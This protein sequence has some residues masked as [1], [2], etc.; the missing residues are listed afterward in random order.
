MRKLSTLALLAFV[1]SAHALVLDDFSDGDF[2]DE[3]TTGFNV[4]NTPASVIGGSRFV[5]HD[6]VDGNQFGLSHRVTVTNGIF[7]S[8]ARSGVDPYAEIRWG[9]SAAGAP[10]LATDL[11]F[12]FSAYTGFQIDV[13]FN[14][15]VADLT[16]YLRSSGVNGGSYAASLTK[17]IGPVAIGNPQTV[18]F[19]FSEWADPALIADVDSIVLVIDGGLD[20]DIVLDN[21]EAVPEPATLALA[22]LGLVAL[23]AKRKRKSA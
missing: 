10:S 5:Y 19:D 22:S 4:V 8:N 11:N 1:A 16:L 6:V 15:V 9:V 14:D 7:A 21:F 12:D 17:N 2:S 23:A 18:L 3:I 13:L 20:N